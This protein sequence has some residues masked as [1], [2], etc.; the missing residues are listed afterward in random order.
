MRKKA[1]TFGFKKK[2]KSYLKAKSAEG[3]KLQVEIIINKST[4]LYVMP[5]F[6]YLIVLCT[7]PQYSK[8]RYGH[9][10]FKSSIICLLY[11]VSM[12]TIMNN[13]S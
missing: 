7:A 2:R 4:V 10:L 8:M 13:A 12:D 5:T 9:N 3:L 6:L 1:L 11:F